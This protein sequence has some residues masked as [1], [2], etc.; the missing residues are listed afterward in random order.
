MKQ[1]VKVYLAV[2]GANELGTVSTASCHIKKWLTMCRLLARQSQSVDNI[3]QY[4]PRD[5]WSVKIYILIA[6]FNLLKVFFL[7]RGNAGPCRWFI[8]FFVCSLTVSSRISP[9]LFNIFVNCNQNFFT[10]EI[11]ISRRIGCLLNFHQN[12]YLVENEF[13]Y[14]Y[15]H[16]GCL[17]KISNASTLHAITW[18]EKK[19]L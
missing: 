12:N 9:R 17:E 15:E 18:Y 19:L 11:S 7:Q 6:L 4:S 16:L 13:Y 1:K 2:V 10:L 14:N 8:Y 3:R 5:R